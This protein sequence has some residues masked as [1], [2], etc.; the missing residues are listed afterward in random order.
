MPGFFFSNTFYRVNLEKILLDPA[1]EDV[2]E[3]KSKYAYG[4]PWS[5][6]HYVRSNL[7]LFCQIILITGVKVVKEPLS[8]M[9]LKVNHQ[10]CRAVYNRIHLCKQNKHKYACTYYRK[11]IIHT[12]KWYQWLLLLRGSKVWVGRKLRTVHPLKVIFH[13]CVF[14]LKLYFRQ[15][16]K[17]I[18]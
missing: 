3:E 6:S 7:G 2:Q 11:C 1:D 16:G 10:R 15:T 5:T 13:V 14:L 18:L 4:R 9:S 17:G 8:L 12:Q